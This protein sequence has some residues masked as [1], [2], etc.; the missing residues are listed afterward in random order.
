MH[1]VYIYVNLIETN[2]PTIV[3][4]LQHWHLHKLFQSFKSSELLLVPQVCLKLAVKQSDSIGIYL[5]I[6][7]PQQFNMCSI[8]SQFSSIWP[9]ISVF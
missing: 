8:A 4:A 3:L 5:L 2:Y 9:Y 1:F 7:M 6:Y